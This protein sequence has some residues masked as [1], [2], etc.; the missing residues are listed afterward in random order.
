MHGLI[1]GVR[2]M[3]C[4]FVYVTSGSMRKLWYIYSRDC[5]VVGKF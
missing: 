5:D 2:V 4:V 3:K 1:G